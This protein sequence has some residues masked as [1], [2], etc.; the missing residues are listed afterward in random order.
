MIVVKT[1]V[2]LSSAPQK[3]RSTMGLNSFTR[4]YLFY[5]KSK[6]LESYV[7]FWSRSLQATSGEFQATSGET[8][9]I[10]S[11]VFGAVDPASQSIQ[12][13]NSVHP[14][15]QEQDADHVVP[16]HANIIVHNQFKN[17]DLQRPF[18]SFFSLH[19]GNSSPN[20][21]IPHGACCAAPASKHSY[22][23]LNFFICSSLFSLV[24]AS[25]FQ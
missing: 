5:N 8:A 17:L 3:K 1:I 14:Q 24:D 18:W 9:T 15:Y 12:K 23:G 22:S 13:Q 6:F 10:I 25:I 16:M 4:I 2:F 7:G 11:S 20:R 19:K 21:L